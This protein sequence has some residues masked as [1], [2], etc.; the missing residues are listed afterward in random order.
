MC[1]G[2]GPLALCLH[3]FPDIGLEVVDDARTLVGNNVTID[4]IEGAG[5][6]LHLEQTDAVN[7]RILEF[8]S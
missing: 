6:F 1:A 4:V 2:D 7:M 5:H 3:G 8:L